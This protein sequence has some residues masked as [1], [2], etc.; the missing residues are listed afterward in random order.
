[1]RG[2]ATGAFLAL[3]SFPASSQDSKTACQAI[4]RF[5]E[6]YGRPGVSPDERI[7]AILELSA[8]KHVKVAQVLAPLL[9][10]ATFPERI[11]IGTELGKFV[12]VEGVSPLLLSAY[13]HKSNE[14][15]R[16]RGVR[17][18]LLKSL[19]ELKSP[20][21]VAVVD[22]SVEDKDVW[23]SKAAIDAAGKIR[24]KSSVDILLR[25]LR[26]IEGP[27]GDRRVRLE[28]FGSEV[29][30]TDVLGVAD[31]ELKKKQIQDSEKEQTS[32]ERDVLKPALQAALESITRH[33][34]ANSKDWQEWWRQKRAK[35]EVPP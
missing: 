35:F 29:P 17:V 9:T 34:G 4:K 8:V 30:A 25:A 33:T 2:A 16:G 13:A 27:E 12:G 7:K 21:A 28:L 20:C 18:V 19:G 10:R 1:M 26:R 23:V 3:L 5:D 6:E 32:S 24:V 22:R 11:I 14:K 15:E 31:E